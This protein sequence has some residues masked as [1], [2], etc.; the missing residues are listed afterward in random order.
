[1][2]D[3]GFTAGEQVVFTYTHYLKD[4]DSENRRQ[5]NRIVK[6]D[7][8]AIFLR[9]RKKNAEIKFRNR[10]GL[11]DIRTVEATCLRKRGN[12]QE[13]AEIIT[14]QVQEQNMDVCLSG[15]GG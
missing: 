8:P 3:R 2:D 4:Y 11:I 13:T 10:V 1:M 6:E 9:W 12:A 5:R 14:G 7:I 15:A